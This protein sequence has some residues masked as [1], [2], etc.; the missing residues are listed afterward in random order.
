MNKLS[1]LHCCFYDILRALMKSPT[2]RY[3]SFQALAA[4]DWRILYEMS[5]THGLTAIIYTQL[6]PVFEKASITAELQR[7]WRVHS[8]TIDQKMTQRNSICAEFA[9]KMA[10]KGIPVVALKG[11]AYSIYYPSP[12]LRECGDLDCY[13]LGKKE[14]GDLAIVE[15]GGRK[16]EDGPKHSHLFFKGLTIENHQFFTSFDNT[17]Q[18]KFTEKVLGNLLSRGCSYLPGTKILSPNADFTV[19]FLIKHAHRHFLYEGIRLRHVLDWAFFLK[20]EQDRINWELCLPIMEQCRILNFAR[21][22]TDLCVKKFGLVVG[23]DKLTELPAEV[24]ALRSVFLNDIMGEQP[25]IYDTNFLKKICRIF[26]RLYRMWK[27]RSVLDDSYIR[28]IWNVFAF[29]SLWNRKLEL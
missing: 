4:D 22:M 19:V 7:K 6:K 25:Q 3:D 11:V 10:Q 1:Q 8:L 2:M 29:S 14:A 24:D 17:S 28:T 12:N 5:V 27:Y 20:A 9:E 23:V 26:R 18:G 15:I 16:E 13:M 21:L